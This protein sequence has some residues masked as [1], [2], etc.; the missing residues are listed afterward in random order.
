MPHTGGGG[1][2]VGG[3]D[4]RTGGISP[5]RGP[6]RRAHQ[7]VGRGLRLLV[8]GGLDHHPDEGLGSAPADQHSAVVAELG[9]HRRD[10]VGQRRGDVQALRGDAHVLE[11]LGQSGHRR[12]GQVR[13]GSLRATHDVEEL[14]RGQQPVARGGQ[15]GEHDV[16]A[17]LPAEGQ[18]SVRHGLQHVSVTDGHLQDLDA[19]LRHP[20]PEPEVGHHGDDDRVL[21]QATVGVAI[22][23]ADPD[24]LIAVDQPARGIDGQH[25]IGVAVEGE[26]DVGAAGHDRTPKVIGVG[27]AAVRVDVGAVRL[28][29]DHLHRRAERPEHSRGD[30]GGGP[31]GT[32]DHDRQPRQPAALDGARPP[33][34]PSDP[35]RTS[36][37]RSCRRPR[38]FS[39]TPTPGRRAA[40]AAPSPAAPRP[41]RRAS[42]RPR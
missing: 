15:V 10:V 13:E 21:G 40:R 4:Q 30:C 41:R 18:I 37:R 34:R 29:V 17:L 8:G 36:H 39:P 7:A 3:P 20:Q 32:V 25:P 6:P 27:R 26:P 1:L 31:V 12:V 28:V 38:P 14:D 35:R 9:L 16:P 11:H 19:V 42:C 5:P 22:D 33:I 2:P 24:D 23:G